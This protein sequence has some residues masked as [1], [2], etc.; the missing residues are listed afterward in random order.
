M[1][2]DELRAISRKLRTHLALHPDDKDADQLQIDA[3]R[4]LHCSRHQQPINACERESRAPAVS[5]TEYSA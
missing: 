4:S 1:T 2:A 5:K 3:G